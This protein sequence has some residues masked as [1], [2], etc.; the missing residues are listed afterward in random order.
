MPANRLSSPSA[1]TRSTITLVG[2]MVTITSDP[3]ASSRRLSAAKPPTCWTKLLATCRRESLILTLK[4]AFTR[5]AAIGQPMLPAPTK[6][7]DAPL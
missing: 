5:Q 7:T 3:A 1:S 2:S 6:P 4:P